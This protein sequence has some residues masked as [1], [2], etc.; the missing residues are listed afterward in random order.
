MQTPK[1]QKIKKRTTSKSQTMKNMTNL[2]KK[3]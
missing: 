2:K 1:E 3:Q